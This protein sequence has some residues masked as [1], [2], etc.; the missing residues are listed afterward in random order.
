MNI[1]FCGAAQEVTGSCHLISIGDHKV[2]L[3]AGLFQGHRKE[4][5]EKNHNLLFDPAELD[6]V[7]LS[8]AHVDHCGLLPLLYAKGFRGKVF[9]TPATCD[10][11]ELILRDSAYIQE[12]NAEVW[13]KRHKRNHWITP[14]YN[15]EHAMGVLGL[16][17]PKKT[18]EKFEVVP[19]MEVTFYKA[20]HILGSAQEVIELTENGKTTRIFFTGDLGRKEMPIVDDPE[21]IPEADILITES[22][23]G[24]RLHHKYVE[25]RQ[26]FLDAIERTY[27]RGGKVLIPSFALERTQEIVYLLHEAFNNS[28]LPRIPIYVD[29]PLATN[30]TQ[31]F[32]KHT[33]LYDVETMQA[34]EDGDPFGF[35]L[36]KYTHSV[37]D[38]KKLTASQKPCII[39]SASGMCEAGRILHHLEFGIEDEK[40]TIVIVGYMAQGTLGRAIV[41]GAPEVKIFG[42]KHKL[43]AEVE[44]FNNF[45]AHADRE[46]IEKHLS[47]TKGIKKAFVIHGEQVAAESL[48]GLLENKFQ[49]SDIEIPERG[50][51]F[52]L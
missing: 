2:A 14:L 45:S 52:E 15:Q 12:H 34:F 23:Y 5:D 7:V 32:R 39:I 24:N 42:D 47:H 44:I 10:L 38:S 29:S 8:H 3:D 51:V 43:R 41:E 21:Y 1:K 13:N 33:E 30:L 49:I 35:G 22:T 28:E 11:A 40:N 18:H 25:A 20:G 9:A 36:L 46:E 50:E 6:A 16:F 37:E 17:V 26:R 27:D 48:A 31:V 19:G 4:A